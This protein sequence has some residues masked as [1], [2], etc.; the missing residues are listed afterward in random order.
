MKV[1]GVYDQLAPKIVQGNNISQTLQFVETGN[2]E[3]GFVAL[4][5]VVSHNAGSRWEVAENLYDPI[6]QD[7]VLLT[8][9]ADSDAARAFVEFLQGPEAEAIIAR[10]GYGSGHPA[11]RG[12]ARRH[13]SGGSSATRAKR[14]AAVAVWRYR[15]AVTLNQPLKSEKEVSCD[16]NGFFAALRS[17][18]CSA[19]VGAGPEH[20]G[21]RPPGA[22]D[23]APSAQSVRQ[24]RGRDLQRRRSIRVR[25]QRRRDQ[26]T[27]RASA[28]PRARATS[29]SSPCSRTARSPWS[30]SA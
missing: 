4:A 19:P 9:G 6:R 3:L 25:L 1:P 24:P 27:G 26:R 13:G 15:V 20:H 16:M 23:G 10:Y 2:A 5:Q 22:G 11:E 17:P 21:G 7:A 30:R 29:A 18:P 8:K 28:G 14:L 12:A